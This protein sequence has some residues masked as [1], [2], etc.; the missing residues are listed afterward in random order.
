MKLPKHY[1]SWTTFLGGLIAVISLF[2]IIILFLASLILDVGDN[3]SGLFT[4]IILPALM[5]AGLALMFI[6][7]IRSRRKRRL[8]SS[9]TAKLPIVDFNDPKQRMIVFVLTIGLSVFVVLSALGGYQ[10]FHYT[11]SN[12]FCGTVCHSV[13]EP[14]YTAYQ[15]SAHAR[16]NCVECHVGS[17]VNW[18]V[19]SKLSG[20]Y[21]VYSVMA[22]AYPRPIPTPLHDLRPAQETCEKCHWPEKFYDRKFV[23]HKHYLA[24]EENTEWDIAMVMKTG[25]AYRALGQQEG[26]HWHINSNVKIEY[27]STN[28]KRDTIIL[29]KYTDLLSGEVHIYMDETYPLDQDQISNLEFRTM[30]CLDCH[31]RPSHDYKSPQ[32]FFDDAMTSG[33]ISSDLPDIKVAAMD[34]LRNVFP[35]KDS[36][37]SYIESEIYGYYDMLYP[38]L[39]ETDKETID[40]AILA[41]K[42]GYSKNV[43]PYMKADWK[44]YPNFM[45]HIENN[46]CYRCHNDRFKS[47]EQ[48]RTISRDCTLCHHIKQQGPPDEMM[49]ATGNDFLE[50]EHPVDIKGKW[51][52]MFCAECH[53]EL[54]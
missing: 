36:A 41:I 3:Y 45:G 22:G 21:Q 17:G 43:F 40:R 26:I 19:K 8:Q 38:E 12:Q 42:E 27:A 32:R 34:I 50:F 13:M 20:L 39:M 24:D 51:K 30:D 10:A 25:P 35:T 29:V 48:T 33:K 23:F 9:E 4:F 44:A 16:V 28:I 46:G 2:M 7:L 54:Y 18:Y 31:N 37:F 15:G 53:N 52:T 11:E 5:I 47:T 6:G 1:F 14:E 49:Y